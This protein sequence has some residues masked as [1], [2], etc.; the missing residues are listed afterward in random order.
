[1]DFGKLTRTNAAISIGEWTSCIHSAPD[2]E[3]VPDKQSVNPFTGETI[4]VSGDGKAFYLNGGQRIGNI[5]LEGGSLLTTGVPIERCETLAEE[6][7]AVF[8]LDDRS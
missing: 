8:E 4:E 2:L 6:L 1:M 7:G 5:S 3:A